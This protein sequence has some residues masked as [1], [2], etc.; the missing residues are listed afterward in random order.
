MELIEYRN[1]DRTQNKISLSFDDG[2]NPY[3]TEKVL[4]ILNRYNIK[5]IFFI[6]GKYVEKYPELVKKIIS[7]GH[8]IGNHGYSHGR[9]INSSD[10][11]KAE[12]II[13][14]ITGQ[15][16]RY[17]RPPF[18]NTRL[19]E[20]YKCVFTGEVKVVNN[21]VVAKDWKRNAKEILSN[22]LD[23]TANGSIILLHDGSESENELETRPAEMLKALPLI[24]EKLSEN[25]TIV[26]LDELLP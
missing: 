9:V 13:Y 22:I 23:K 6:L 21:D 7:D 20:S 5:T 10:F 18:N 19:C 2:P 24:I 15:N 4:N 12:K 1:G 11:E 14:N 16:T 17:L 3:F 8:L 25:F 26:R